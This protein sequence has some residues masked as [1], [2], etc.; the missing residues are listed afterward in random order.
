MYESRDPMLLVV[1][2]ASGGGRRTLDV[3]DVRRVCAATRIMSHR[4]ENKHQIRYG[5]GIGVYKKSCCVGEEVPG[6][7]L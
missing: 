4:V 5:L 6:D 7:L 2:N 3:R 1:E